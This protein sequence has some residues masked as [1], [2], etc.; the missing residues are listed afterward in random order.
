[1]A[2]GWIGDIEALTLRND[3]F[4]TV[5]FTG[6]HHQLTVMSIPQGGEIGL[7]VHPDNDHSSGSSR[8]TP[9]SSSG[10]RKAPST[11]RAT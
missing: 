11:S 5:V 6:E 7:E 2:L 10:A 1:M 9:A 3:T 8:A 4:R